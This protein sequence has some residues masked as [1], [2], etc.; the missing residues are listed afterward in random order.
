M[1]NVSYQNHILQGLNFAISISKHLFILSITLLFITA[2]GGPPQ[3]ADENSE[4]PA[5]LGFT[6][7]AAPDFGEVLTGFSYQRTLEIYNGSLT[8]PATNV[9][10]TSGLDSGFS[11]AGGTFPGS[12]GTCG[13]EIAAGATC[14]IVV[15]LNPVIIG[16]L[17]SVLTLSYFDGLADQEAN[18]TLSAQ[19][20]DPLPGTLTFSPSGDH[21]FGT[22]AIGGFSEIT[23][24]VTNAG[25][26]DATGVTF[27]GVAAPFTIDSNTCGATVSAGTNCQVVVRFS[28]PAQTTY[29]TALTVNY[30]DGV[31][32]QTIIKN[33]DGE[34]RVA[35][36]LAI[37]EGY[38]F[39]FGLINNTFFID[40][41]LT[42]RNTG[43]GT[44]STVGFTGL[45]APFS[46]QNN[47]CPATLAPAAVC[48]IVVRFTP[49]ATGSFSDTGSLNFF[50][51][52][53]NQTVSVDL[54][55][56]GFAEALSLSLQSPGSSPSNADT[57]TIRVSNTVNGVRIRLYSSAGCGS[58]VGNSVSTGTTIDFSPTLAEGS[59]QFHA[60]AEDGQGN[61]SA[62]SAASV[63]YQYDNS[64]P[65]AP[66]IPVL[67]S[68]F[69]TSN[70]TTPNF[71][72][73]HSGSG[74]V[75]DYEVGISAN[76][77]GGNDIGGFTS[78]GYVTSA[79][80]SGLSL[81]EC[82]DY[83][84]SLRA[85]DGVGLFSPLAVSATTFRYDSAVP[86]NPSSLVESNDASDTNSATVSWNAS[87][88]ACGIDF[89]EVAVSEDTNGNSVL[90]PGEIG[91]VVAFSNVGN[92]TT[93][94][95]DGLTGLTTGLNHYTSIR[96]VDT[97]GRTSGTVVS[98]PWIIYNPSIELPDMVL[99]LDANDPATI[100]DADGDDANSGGAFSGVI[101]TWLDKSG[102]TTDH[103]FVVSSGSVGPNY[104]GVNFSAVFDGATTGMTVPD[105]P[106]LNNA[107]VTQRNLTT[108]FRT[109]GDINTRQVIYDE[110]GSIRGMN[111]YVFNGRIYCGFYNTPND[112]DGS[113]PFTSVSAPAATNT[114]YFVTW[115]FDYTNYAG[116]GGP[117]G[118]LTCYVN[119]TVI[120][121]STSTSRLFA[122]SGNIGIGHIDNQS[123]FEDGSCPASD[124]HFLGDL[125]EVMIFN[126]VPDA[127]DVTNV[128]TFLSNKWN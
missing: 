10:V 7:D 75:V 109:S 96:A 17:S 26:L 126:N 113:Q 5:T 111:I 115:V 122:H 67:A 60:R 48:T 21:D 49:T 108:A 98:D 32:P 88:D 6:P 73:T 103:D 41:N 112:G 78:K 15:D 101:A 80:E 93:H 116:A 27:S 40:Q 90:D 50:D 94:R 89:Y 51:G 102:S 29:N 127:A 65:T 68:N 58:E 62:C 105:H 63:A 106:D 72:W 66:G 86:T 123:C 57:P 3:Q 79:N 53:N 28:P 2:C 35:G 124:N 59:Y 46:V 23:Y 83:F 100:L 119:D 24:T 85:E 31:S 56:E 20:R 82:N 16:N 39:D 30:N 95:F 37:N 43:G 55:G 87:S 36:F 19:S 69:T 128:H 45:A 70:S 61:L 4:G 121:T 110:G 1:L 38:D 54:A 42:V 84:V 118:D 52:F 81:T 97:T 74:D 8:V 107:T 91:N 33:F 114:T 76:P 25:E 44:A 18:F 34:G 120:G 47:F 64:A 71:N 117:D 92:I 99:W 104:D 22:I 12:G 9:T 11:F 14:S 13:I 77:A 125:Y